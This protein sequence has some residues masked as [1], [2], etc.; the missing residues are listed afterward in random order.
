M[1]IAVVP[2]LTI[3]NVSAAG[4]T[5]GLAGLGSSIGLGGTIVE[6]VGMIAIAELL[7]DSAIVGFAYKSM[8][9]YNR[10][11][12]KKSF[13]EMDYNRAAHMLAIK[14]YLMKRAKSI[15]PSNLYKEKISELLQMIQDLKSDTDYL[16]F[17]ERE[18]PE[19]NK[20]KIRVF[21]NM[22]KKLME[23]L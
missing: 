5:G 6:G 2:A 4:I 3:G 7:L 21:H 14:C 12:V 1:A 11:I 17:V 18:L 10:N 8:D 20:N 22:D 19:V 15:M 9:M 13:R 23:M 16:L